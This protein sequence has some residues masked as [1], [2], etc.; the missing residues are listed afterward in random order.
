MPKILTTSITHFGNY[1]ITEMKEHLRD[2]GLPMN[3]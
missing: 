1:T 3:L 2:R